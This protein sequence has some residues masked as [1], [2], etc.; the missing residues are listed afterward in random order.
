MNK[1]RK[2]V[3]SRRSRMSSRH[4]SRNSKEGIERPEKEH[5]YDKIFSK[6]VTA[7]I[8]KNNQQLVKLSLGEFKEIQFEPYFPTII[9]DMIEH[10]TGFKI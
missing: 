8:K 6:K 5:P 1:S 7:M 9:I 2:S 4:S 3:G 10:L